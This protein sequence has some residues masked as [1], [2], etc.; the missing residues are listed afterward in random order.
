VRKY[1]VAAAVFVE[2]FARDLDCLPKD[3]RIQALL[4]PDPSFIE[5]LKKDSYPPPKPFPRFADAYGSA[6]VDAFKDHF[7]AVKALIDADKETGKQWA[8]VERAINATSPPP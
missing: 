6:G 8:E 2:Q 1:Y 4:N 3:S 7:A 5:M